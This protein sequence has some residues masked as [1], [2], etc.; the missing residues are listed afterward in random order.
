M[1]AVKRSER[2]MALEDILSDLLNGFK[3]W[4]DSKISSGELTNQ[5]EMFLRWVEAG[6][7]ADEL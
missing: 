2:E 6:P 4:S 5:D 7:V 1:A 3:I